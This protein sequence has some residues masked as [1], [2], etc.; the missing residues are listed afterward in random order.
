MILCHHTGG[1]GLGDSKAIAK[2]LPTNVKRYFGMQHT[3]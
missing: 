1:Y 3:Q 2:S